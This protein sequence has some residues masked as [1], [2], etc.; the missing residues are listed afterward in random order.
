MKKLLHFLG[1]VLFKR[2]EWRQDE[3]LS[4]HKRINFLTV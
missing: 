4:I 2:K 3:Y 1:N